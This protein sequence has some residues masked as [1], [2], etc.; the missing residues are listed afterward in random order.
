MQSRYNSPYCQR[1]ALVLFPLFF[2][3]SLQVIRHNPAIRVLNALGQSVDVVQDAGN[4]SGDFIGSLACP[5]SLAA[6]A[7][8]QCVDGDIVI[9]RKDT[10]DFCLLVA[11]PDQVVHL[12]IISRMARTIRL[13]CRMVCHGDRKGTQH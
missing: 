11:V 8:L 13:R 4:V 9:R 6:S 1:S 10:D 5:V 2:R 7:V 3:V 12:D